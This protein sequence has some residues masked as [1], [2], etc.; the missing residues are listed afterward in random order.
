MF[1]MIFV[2]YFMGVLP[3][4]IAG[5][6]RNLLSVG[7]SGSEAGMTVNV[8]EGGLVFINILNSTPVRWQ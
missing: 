3:S 7:D 8:A 4:V 2:I 6:T 5:L 1:H